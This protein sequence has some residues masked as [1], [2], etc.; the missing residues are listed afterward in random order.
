MENQLILRDTQ[1]RRLLKKVP[2][3]YY[4]DMMKDIFKSGGFGV[5]DE[6][7]IDVVNKVMHMLKP[8]L[9]HDMFKHNIELKYDDYNDFLKWNYNI[10]IINAI[11]KIN[12]VDEV[13]DPYKLHLTPRNYIRYFISHLEKAN[14]A[15]EAFNNIAAN[16][17]PKFPYLP[18]DKIVDRLIEETEGNNG[19]G[20]SETLA[21]VKRIPLTKNRAVVID[22][23]VFHSPMESWS[24]ID[25]ILRLRNI[26]IG[27]ILESKEIQYYSPKD[28]SFY[29]GLV[30][31][32]NAGIKNWNYIVD[33][34][35]KKSKV[36]N[37]DKMRMVR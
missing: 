37:T 6:I 30:R 5:N 1:V 29:E 26:G 25:A 14:S 4:V 7:D 28:Q 20:V 24:E 23:N 12:L 27:F 17:K 10:D 18:Q 3:S 35:V 16:E 2:V 21:R 22:F 9:Q 15:I 8:N 31:G 11:V 13:F 33:G 34:G 32:M 19:L 36:R